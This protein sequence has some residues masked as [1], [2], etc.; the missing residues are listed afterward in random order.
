MQHSLIEM[1]LA[2]PHPDS[3]VSPTGHS[4]DGEGEGE[5]GEGVE[6][7]MQAGCPSLVR[8]MAEIL[9][10]TEPTKAPGGY[11][12]TAEGEKTIM[13]SF[14]VSSYLHKNWELT[15]FLLFLSPWSSKD[16]NHV[17]Y[18]FL[19]ISNSSLYLREKSIN[20]SL[21][22]NNIFSLFL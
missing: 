10:V 14:L 18:E 13:Y 16:M 12:A 15:L 9:V 11:E 2:V 3:W 4:S 19:P 7:D 20:L 22:M 6:D 21:I 17:S 8:W 5:E 1:Q